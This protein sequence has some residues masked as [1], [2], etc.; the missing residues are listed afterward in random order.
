MD[1]I[2]SLLGAKLPLFPTKHQSV[3]EVEFITCLVFEFGAMPRWPIIYSECA[4]S[5]GLLSSVRVDRAK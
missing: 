5:S 4:R 1:P 2:E 3:M